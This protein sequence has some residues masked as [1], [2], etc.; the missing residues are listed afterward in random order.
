MSRKKP[1]LNGQKK[2]P[3]VEVVWA[4]ANHECDNA[5][6]HKE[7]KPSR[8]ITIGY[9]IKEHENGDLVVA[10]ELD[11][12]D[13]NWGRHIAVIPEGMIEEYWEIG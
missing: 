8:L 4:D 2:P 12:G 7:R 6:L 10:Q 13:P 11:L 5:E 1:K 3:R 9:L